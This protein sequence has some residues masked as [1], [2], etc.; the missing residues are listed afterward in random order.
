MQV[1]MSLAKQTSFILFYTFH[2][3]P[4]IYFDGRINCNMMAS[5]IHAEPYL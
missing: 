3:T 5:E 4:C 1:H 2:H